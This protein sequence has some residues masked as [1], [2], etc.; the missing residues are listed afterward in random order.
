MGKFNPPDEEIAAKPESFKERL[1][2]ITA[3]K[4]KLK[5]IFNNQE[6]TAIANAE[7]TETSGVT[8]PIKHIVTDEIIDEGT[9]NQIVPTQELNK[10]TNKILKIEQKQK[11]ELELN[12][13][14]NTLQKIEDM[15]LSSIGH[16]H[17]FN[18][19]QIAELGRAASPIEE[20]AAATLSTP[21]IVRRELED[22]DSPVSIVYNRAR[23][24]IHQSLRRAQIVSAIEGDSTMQK[25][26][27]KQLLGQKDSID[28]NSSKIDEYLADDR[29]RI[30]RLEQLSRMLGEVSVV[31][32]E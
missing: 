27:G 6:P 7:Q 26:L 31:E 22:L 11:F 23:V 32:D 14:V 28:L 9:K 18:L 8:K 16:T 19:S 20:I 13:L 29:K 4:K 5:A 24:G 30:A 25:W 17:W 12:D 3:E 15:K 2:R 1:A 21:A 10:N